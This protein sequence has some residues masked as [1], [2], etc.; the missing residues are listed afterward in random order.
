MLHQFS[1]LLP[2]ALQL[3][4]QSLDQFMRRRSHL[5]LMVC[6]G[7]Y[8]Q[9]LIDCG[10]SRHA[11]VGPHADSGTQ[12]APTFLSLLR[13]YIQEQTNSSQYYPIAVSTYLSG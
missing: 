4:L 7:N 5:I 1:L 10:S 9:R 6:L 13:N 11:L 8:R 2:F 3:I 12:I